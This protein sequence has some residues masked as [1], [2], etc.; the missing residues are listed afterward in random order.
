MVQFWHKPTF[1]VSHLHSSDIINAQIPSKLHT[2]TV[3]QQQLPPSTLSKFYYTYQRPS[4]G[5][6]QPGKCA[7]AAE[8]ED[9]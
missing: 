2:C 3:V 8:A 7:A 4:D 9:E 1:D 5:R 6:E